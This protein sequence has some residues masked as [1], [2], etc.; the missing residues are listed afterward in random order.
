MQHKIGRVGHGFTTGEVAAWLSILV[1]NE[2]RSRLDKR[3]KLSS[4]TFAL[5]RRPTDKNKNGNRAKR[6]PFLARS[7]R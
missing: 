6:L 7:A 4:A 1:W 2:G 3:Q 5:W